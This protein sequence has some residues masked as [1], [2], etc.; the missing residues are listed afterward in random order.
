MVR[1]DAPGLFAVPPGV[2]F[3]RAVVEGLL[4]RMRGCAP[5]ELARVELYVNTRRMH[6]R[7]SGLFDRHGARLLPRIRL[8]PDIGRNAVLPGVPPAAPPLRRRLDMARLV[9]AL[10]DADPSAGP[11][12]SLYD[13]TD[14]LARLLDELQG[15]GL[16]ADALTGIDRADLSEHWQR[17]RRFLSVVL[18]YLAAA[19]HRAPDPE[20]RQRRAVDRMIARWQDAPP[21]H[22][23]V[24]AGSTGSRGTTARLMEAVARLPRG[25]VILPGFDFDQP[26]DVWAR[27]D[28]IDPAQDHP[29]FRFRALMNRLRLAPGD[30]RRWSDARPASDRR[31][32]LVSLALRPAPVTD[33][34][35]RE[36]PALGPLDP[37]TAGLTLVEAPDKRVEANVI[38]LRLR[39]AVEEGRTAALVTPDRMLTRRVG[40][41]LDTWNI[42]PDDSAGEPLA[43]S[44][45][46]R[47]LRHVA[48]LLGERALIEDLIVVLKHP[49]ANDGSGQRGPH[50]NLTRELELHL[51]RHGPPRPDADVLTNWADTKGDDAAEWAR[52]IAEL[53]DRWT[54]AGT[55]SLKTLV[56]AHV[57]IAERLAQGPRGAGSGTLW[58][59][60][61][62]EKAREVVQEL[63]SEAPD[64]QIFTPSEYRAL[65]DGILNRA[66]VR[67]A[68]TP[69][70]DIMFW[71]TLES[72][73]HG[74]DLLILGGLN[75]G[76]WPDLPEH[77]PWL[78]R[79]MR[80]AAGL[81]LPERQIGLSAHDFQQAIAA[82]E[83]MLTRAKRSEDAGTVPSR[84]L[85]RIT[86]LLDGL[87]DTGRPALAAMRERGEAWLDLARALEPV[88]DSVPPVPRPAPRP[89]VAARPRKLSVTQI[90]TLIRDP[91]AIYA[92]EVLRLRPVDPLRPGPDP[93]D[94]GT[95][96]HDIFE[97]FIRDGHHR[98][99][100]TARDTL[101]RI[102]EET[103]AA[104]AAWPVARRLWLA[105]I[106]RVADHFLAEEALR[107]EAGDPLELEGAAEL[108]LPESDFTLRAKADRIDRL[109]SGD[110]V[111]Y[112]YKTGSI[113]SP[114]KIEH[115][116]K[117]LLLE[118]MM[119]E[120]GAF[121]GIGAARV[122][123]A[124]HIGLGSK[125]GTQTVELVD[126]SRHRFAPASVRACLAKL[127]AAYDDP[128]QG[129]VS[130]R[131]MEQDAFAADYDHLARLGEWDESAATDG[132]DV[133]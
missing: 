105:A 71:G 55:G 122:D 33:Q 49:L 47:F 131:A 120:A 100:D 39:R 67:E 68:T 113:P 59:R 4:D 98:G 43:L 130:R 5:D 20:E 79:Q 86:N 110:L 24:V 57:D 104:D 32:A 89:P 88:P 42:R 73:V 58:T 61:A 94:R 90:Q 80:K 109:R 92:R 1:D 48:A 62:G 132:E 83:V 87:P 95:I 126:D 51:R 8:I 18:D 16:D 28:T 3:P 124:A 81:L 121:A 117:Q 108:H 129:Y 91:Y 101:L 50:L 31:N 37:A 35:M 70:P 127:I 77:D 128:R 23:V 56:S 10:L 65:F 14:S 11:S 82:D 17:R 38:A 2:D 44:A 112:D 7:I 22:P 99:P 9:A 21:D 25:L 29:Q 63:V 52:W 96:V 103:F 72:R 85:N 97:R 41:M 12:G 46:G 54:A 13:L 118:A 102:A 123:H 75:E 27:L 60:A 133:S 116:D 119:V 45:P 78:N 76:S 66:E 26:E 84:W 106:A 115:F 114:D 6:R 64:D 125:P 30:V 15:E 19:P 74:A 53:S 107:A 36:G 93:R 111:I 69:H 34:W 40:A